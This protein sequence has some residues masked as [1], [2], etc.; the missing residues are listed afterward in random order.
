MRKIFITMLAAVAAISS[1]AQG[2]PKIAKEIKA[3]KDFNAGKAVLDQQISTLTDEQLGQA[4]SELYKLALPAA[5]KTVE[6]IEAKNEAGIDYKA[7][8]TAVE[9]ATMCDKYN[10]KNAKEVNIEMMAYRPHLIN[11]ANSTTD[12]DDKLLYSMAYINST[13]LKSMAGVLAGDDP[14][15]NLANF[16]ASVSFYQKK[17]FANA[18]KYSKPAIADAQ[19]SE[20]AEQI[21]LSCIAQNLDTKQDTIKYIE[22]LQELNPDKY[23]TQIALLYYYTGESG[24]VDEIVKQALAKDPNNKMAYLVRGTM[25]GE[26]KKYEEALGDYK[27][28]VEIDPNY[29]TGWENLGVCYTNIASDIEINHADKRTGRVLGDYLVKQKAAFDGAIEAYEKVR[30]LDPDRKTVSNWPMQLRMLYNAIGNKA[31]VEEINKILGEN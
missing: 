9:M 17:D 11:A 27:K 10:A 30:E 3:T 29:I 26:Q 1:F 31:K 23:F 4:Y 24:K 28:V 19:V 12:T 20:N 8:A 13:N 16:F 6:A 2:N 22:A 14:Y 21:Y 25:L 5:K 7:I 15:V 18:A